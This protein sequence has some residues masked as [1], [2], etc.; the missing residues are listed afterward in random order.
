MAG[1]RQGLP[2]KVDVETTEK[3][4]VIARAAEASGME[5][6]VFMREAA[7]AVAAARLAEKTLPE[8]DTPK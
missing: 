4:W 1:D 8:E 7:L 2:V 5:V 3:F 6:P